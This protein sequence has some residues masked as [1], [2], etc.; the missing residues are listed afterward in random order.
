MVASLLQAGLGG[1][2]AS[3]VPVESFVPSTEGNGPAIVAWVVWSGDKHLGG[4]GCSRV[5]R[6]ET[7]RAGLNGDMMATY[8]R[9]N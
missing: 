3:V 8:Y 7:R 6:D 1:V 9:A 4:V 5:G 2:M